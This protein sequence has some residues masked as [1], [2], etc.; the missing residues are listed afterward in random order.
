MSEQYKIPKNWRWVKLGEVCEFDSGVWGDEPTGSSECYPVLRSNN[1]HNGQMVF[2]DIAIRKINA[3]YVN[4]KKLKTG[5]I[6]ITTSSGS[7]DLLGKSAIFIQPSDGK[8]YLFSNFTMRLS[9]KDEFIDSLF[10]YFYFQSP[11]AK[12]VLKTLQDTTTGLRNLD[13]KQ[14]MSQ[15]IP[16]SPIS[17]QKYIA[18]KIQELMQEVKQAKESCEKQLEASQA[19]PSAYLREVFESDEAKKWEKR[20]LGEVCEIFSGSSAP[21]DLKYFDKGKYPFVRVSDL[22]KNGKTDNLVDI[23]D[24]VNNIAVEKLKLKKAGKGTIIFPKSGA[25]ITTNNRAILGKD[26]FIVSHLAALK[27]KEGV[28]DS[29]FIYY[30]LCLTNMINYLENPG[31]PSLKLSVISKISISLPPIKEQLRIVKEIKEKMKES[32]I[33]QSTI[34]NQQLTIDALPQAVLRKAFRGEL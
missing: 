20:R 1:I 13:R 19:L 5:N 6:L 10:L 7:R 23:R 33:L 25:A 3:K 12:E 14:F 15:L 21:Q 18:A 4:T 24:Y 29:Y 34:R 17:D 31:Y 8:T 28:A 9:P 26:A 2:D 27:P 11:E 22:S 30:W 16:L 32:E